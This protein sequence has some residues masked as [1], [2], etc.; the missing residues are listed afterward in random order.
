MPP[1][2][3]GQ[4]PG[5]V[6]L[7]KPEDQGQ[8]VESGSLLHDLAEQVGSRQPSIPRIGPLPA[9]GQ[10]GRFEQ[11]A[12]MAEKGGRLPEIRG[13]QLGGQPDGL[14]LVFPVLQHQIPGLGGA[15]PLFHKRQVRVSR[16]G[17]FISGGDDRAGNGLNRCKDEKPDQAH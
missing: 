11:V 7:I 4:I 6:F 2:G 13:S 1:T 14:S 3:E 9:L 5:S 10:R 12:G 8:G 16:S 15:T 17:L